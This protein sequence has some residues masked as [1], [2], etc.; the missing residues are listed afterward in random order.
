MT[1][2]GTIYNALLILQMQ[3][4]ILKSP[5]YDAQRFQILLIKHGQNH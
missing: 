2:T 1:N 5:K 3:A 4:K